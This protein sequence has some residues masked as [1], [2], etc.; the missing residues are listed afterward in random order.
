MNQETL[1]SILDRANLPGDSPT[2][3]YMMMLNISAAA[4]NGIFAEIGFR[5]GG[6]LA[7]VIVGRDR[8]PSDL[9]IAIDPYGNIDY[10]EGDNVT[11]H[12]YTN[13]MRAT[14][15]SYFHKFL[16]ENYGDNLNFSFWN[17][18]SLEFIERFN[19]GIP[20]YYT[21]TK[22]IRSDY[23]M[24]HLD[25]AHRTDVVQ[26]EIEYFA[27]RV[28]P[29]GFMVLDNTEMGWMDM[30]VLEASLKQYGFVRDD[31][32]TVPDRWAYRRVQGE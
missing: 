8:H 19:D 23:A 13:S 15:L 6:G 9:F 11:K 22:V 30:E 32:F 24:V 7:T 12:D 31:A 20:D 4:P 3:K 18:E 10:L 16:L 14:A 21:G 5:M 17:L 27:P 1:L 28:L 29:T 25:G 2:Q 26:K